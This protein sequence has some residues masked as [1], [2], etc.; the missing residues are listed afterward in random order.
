MQ[1]EEKQQGSWTLLAVAGKIDTTTSPEFQ[2]RLLA[3][4]EK[5]TPK[6][7]L[8]LGGT[9]YVSSAGIR[10]VMMG[11][12]AQRAKN[13]ELIFCRPNENLRMLFDITGLT[14]LVKIFPALPDAT[15]TG[16]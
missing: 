13:G 14:G 1:M 16:S 6:I 8:D 11:L 10:V 7:A 2:N 4:I 15:G 9:D 3:L 12:K 5:G